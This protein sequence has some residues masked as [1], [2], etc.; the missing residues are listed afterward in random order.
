LI[1]VARDH[2]ATDILIEPRSKSLCLR[3]SFRG[4]SL[5]YFCPATPSDTRAI[6]NATADVCR[7][8]GVRKN[9]RESS[10]PETSKD[11]R[12]AHHAREFGTRIGPWLTA[13][14]DPFAKLALIKER[15]TVATPTRDVEA[16]KES[17]ANKST[18]VIDTDLSESF[19]RYPPCQ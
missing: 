14:P 19:T 12:V 1:K 5:K 17:E 2:G 11:R 10:A 15:M 13:R 3:F 6:D 18:D 9:V 4:K 8:M 16:R 7:L